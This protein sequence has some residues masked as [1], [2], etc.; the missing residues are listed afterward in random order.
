MQNLIQ[1]AAEQRVKKGMS[2]NIEVA[3]EDVKDFPQEQ[4]EKIYA[5]YLEEKTI[6]DYRTNLLEKYKGQGLTIR[7]IVKENIG[8]IKEVC[9]NYL[10]FTKGLDLDDEI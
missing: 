8:E 9:G 5:S 7:E 3:L 10:A 1:I 4:L 2:K 6:E